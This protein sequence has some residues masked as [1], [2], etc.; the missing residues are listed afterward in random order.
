MWMMSPRWH[1]CANLGYLQHARRGSG[2]VG[3][4][5]QLLAVAQAMLMPAAA[6]VAAL[7]KQ[8]L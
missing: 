4:V 1:I 6:A 3:L 5:K 8:A 7:A 2:A